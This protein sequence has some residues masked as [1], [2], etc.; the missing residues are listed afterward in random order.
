M[1]GR[2]MTCAVTLYDILQHSTALCFERILNSILHEK[3]AN[4]L[5]IGPYTLLHAIL[6][7]NV[8]DHIAITKNNYVSHSSI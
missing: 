3:T 1:G 2:A 6:S 5:L 4:E 8:C 7:S